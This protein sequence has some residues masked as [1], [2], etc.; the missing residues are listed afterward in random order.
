MSCIFVERAMPYRV[1]MLPSKVIGHLSK[2]H[3]VELRKYSFGLLVR[4]AQEI[5]EKNIGYYCI[6]EFTICS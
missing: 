1:T 5:P 4:G 6:L 2:S 3:R